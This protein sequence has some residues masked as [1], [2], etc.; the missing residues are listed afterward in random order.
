MELGDAGLWNSATQVFL[1]EEKTVSG[2][3]RVRH[4][5]RGDPSHRRKTQQTKRGRASRQAVN[6]RH[7]N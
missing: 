4:A 7:Q 1:G 6:E 2:K 5:K 3:D